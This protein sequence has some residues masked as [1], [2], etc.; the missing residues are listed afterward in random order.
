MPDLKG[1]EEDRKALIE[2]QRVDKT[3]ESVRVWAERGIYM[4]FR[5]VSLCITRRMS[6]G[7]SGS[8]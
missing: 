1:T 6:R 8:M 3:L 7:K 5:K 4:D 2:Q